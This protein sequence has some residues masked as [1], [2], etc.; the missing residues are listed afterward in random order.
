MTFKVGIDLGTTNSVVAYMK[1]ERP[2]VVRTLEG[3]DWTPSVVQYFNNRLIVGKRAR[4]NLGEAPPGTVAWS[5]KRFIGRMPDDPAM[6][7]A[8]ELVAYSVEAPPAGG[9]ELVIQLADKPF[10]PVDLSAEILRHVVAGVERTLRQKPTHAVITVPAYFTERQKKATER[11]GLAAGLGVLDILDEPSAAALAYNLDLRAEICTVLVFDL[12]GGTFDVSILMI[13]GGMTNQVRI[14]GDNFLGGDDFDN[15]ILA[16]L[17]DRLPAGVRDEAIIKAQLKTVAEDAKIA[18]CNEDIVAIDR[19]LRAPRGGAAIP[20]ST[21]IRRDWFQRA[22]GPLVDRAIA[23][24]H[25]LLARAKHSTDKIDR[26]LMVGGSSRLPAVLD[27]VAAVFG[28]H[29]VDCEIDGML[30]VALGAA[31]RAA[32]LEPPAPGEPAAPPELVRSDPV[33]RVTPRHIGVELHDGTFSVLIPEG[34]VLPVAP[35]RRPYQ[36]AADGQSEIRLAFYEGDHPSAR[37]NEH[38][39]DVVLQLIKPVPRNTPVD[40]TVG[41]DKSGIMFLTISVA[42]KVLVRDARIDREIGPRD[43]ARNADAPRA[44]TME[45]ERR[46][47]AVVR[48]CK[49]VLDA[50]PVFRSEWEGAL[51]AIERAIEM[52]DDDARDAAIA[53]GARLL[54]RGLPPQLWAFYN[55]DRLVEIGRT[56]PGEDKA[57]RAHLQGARDAAAANDHKKLHDKLDDLHGEIQSIV[58]REAP[59]DT[60]FGGILDR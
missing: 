43:R 53:Y 15:I 32:Q 24:V 1:G 55:A 28:A 40:I 60:Q 20:L 18:L 47:A 2:Q 27:G 11:A 5:I 45:V 44:R 34:T 35:R 21:E 8:R 22:T 23:R 6:A 37:Q 48:V 39:N 56:D 51:G 38:I 3:I 30:C 9:D 54:D 31:V 49:P 46:I 52:R 42:D 58:D 19:F 50:Y 10:T 57:L 36:T 4:D 12:G 29:K 7:R 16:E 14:G 25:D 13:S 59:E 26:V 17:Q 33:V 41:L